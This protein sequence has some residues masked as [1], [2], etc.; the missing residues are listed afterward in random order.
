MSNNYPLQ[1]TLLQINQFLSESDL[2]EA[3][4]LS[5]EALADYDNA[6]HTGLLEGN[7]DTS[8]IRNIAEM[9]CAH[10]MCLNM[11]NLNADAISTAIMLLII[12]DASKVDTDTIISET[13]SLYTVATKV[14]YDLA[15]KSE[16]TPTFDTIMTILSRL[17]SMTYHYYQREGSLGINDPK[18]A[19]SYAL[20][21]A[22]KEM[23]AIQSPAIAIDGE[24]ISPD[25]PH[26]ILAD[27]IAL[28]IQAGLMR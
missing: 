1:E 20:L 22:M 9:G 21:S 19:D 10:L 27:T 16:G 23:G 8:L 3:L 7:P 5:G 17:A 4:R 12:I 13:R 11:S 28:A 26:E 15:E 14:A 2:T 24:M 18:R 6:W 25:Q